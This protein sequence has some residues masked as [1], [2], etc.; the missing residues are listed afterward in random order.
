MFFRLEELLGALANGADSPPESAAQVLINSGAPEWVQSGSGSVSGGIVLIERGKPPWWKEVLASL[1]R[2]H[3][4]GT[5]SR[6]EY[7]VFSNSNERYGAL[8]NLSPGFPLMVNGLR[9]QSPEGLEQA[10]KFPGTSNL[11]AEIAAQ[12]DGAAAKKLA[13]G[14]WR[15]IPGWAGL[16]VTAM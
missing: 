1:E 12:S 6:D 15:T 8:S 9:F 10:L 5:V 16:R 7:T 14:D 4:S 11:Q 2:I 13:Y 3:Q